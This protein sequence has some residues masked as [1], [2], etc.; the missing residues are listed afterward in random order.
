MD[1]AGITYGE[2][3]RGGKVCEIKAPLHFDLVDAQMKES[4]RTPG[5]P[6]TTSTLQQEAS[7]KARVR[8]SQT[9]SIAQSLY[10]NGHITYMRTDSV[11]LSDL[12]IGAAKDYIEKPM[13]RITRLQ[14]VAS[15]KI[16]KPTLKKRMKLSDQL[17]LV[18]ILETIG[19]KHK[20]LDCINS[21]GNEPLPV[22]KC[23]KPSLN[24]HLYFFSTRSGRTDLDFQGRSDQIP[25][26]HETLC[27][28]YG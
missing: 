13:E 8:V 1:T 21:F 5:A 3:K 15:T 2:S 25:R 19:L 9:M 27:R 26:V 16:S 20:K 17:I 24:D 6:F 4:A 11:N 7:R 14:E 22:V 12:A 18:K 10:Q 23:R 28:R